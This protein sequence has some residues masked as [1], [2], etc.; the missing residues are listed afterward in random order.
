[1]RNNNVVVVDSLGGQRLIA[2][3]GYI[4]VGNDGAVALYSADNVEDPVAVFFYPVSVEFKL[5]S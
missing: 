5:H 1:M 2:N 4:H 3:I